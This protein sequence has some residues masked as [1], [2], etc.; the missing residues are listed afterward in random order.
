MCQGTTSEPT[1]PAGTVPETD[2]DFCPSHLIL[3]EIGRTAGR[4]TFIHDDSAELMRHAPDP[5][6]LSNYL[7]TRSGA[8]RLAPTPVVRTCFIAEL[9]N[10]SIR[11]FRDGPARNYVAS[12]EP[13]IQSLAPEA[14]Q[15]TEKDLL[16]AVDAPQL[17]NSAFSQDQGRGLP[18]PVWALLIGAVSV[19][20]VILA[21]ALWVA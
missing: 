5:L 14:F 2:R 17:E 16:W 1:G 18:H 12:S 8:E 21:L 13:P 11:P 10:G 9:E 20:A 6:R 7:T 15:P 19:S 3:H 4:G